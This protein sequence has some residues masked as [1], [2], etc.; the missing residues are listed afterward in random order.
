MLRFRDDVF[1]GGDRLPDNEIR[2]VCLLQSHGPQQERLFCRANPQRH[3]V[4]IL[5][6]NSWHDLIPR[7]HIQSV[8]RRAA[9]VNHVRIDF[10]QTP[11]TY[12]PSKTR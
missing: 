3:T 2:Q 6:C 4:V 11:V 1:R 7:W 12:D 10:A 5:D 8:Q 9:E